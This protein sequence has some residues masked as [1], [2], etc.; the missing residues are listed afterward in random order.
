MTHFRSI[1]RYL[2]AS[3][4][5]AAALVSNAYA[6]FPG[7]AISAPSGSPSGAAASTASD[8]S[9]ATALSGTDNKDV[10]ITASFNGAITLPAAS[11]KNGQTVTITDTAGIGSGSANG[12]STNIV[13]LVVSNTGTETIVIDG[14]LTSVTR[15]MLWARG[16]TVTLRSNGSATWFVTARRYWHVDPRSY[17]PLVWYDARRGITLNSSTVSAW[18]D[19]SG[20]GRDLAQST[21]ANQPI[22]L[23]NPS[24]HNASGQNAV[25]FDSTA[26]TMQTAS[27][28]AFASNTTQFL[29]AFEMSW[30]A[31]Q[32]GMLWRTNYDASK[33]LSYFP[34]RSTSSGIGNASSDALYSG[35]GSNLATQVGPFL[36]HPSSYTRAAQRVVVQYAMG[37]G[38]PASIYRSRG[39]QQ[40]LST[41]AAG[42]VGSFTQTII[43]G[44]TWVGKVAQLIIF[45]G[46]LA[47]VNDGMMLEAALAEVYGDK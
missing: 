41:G 37:T 3:L 28:V 6:G 33:G 9:T 20:N 31:A 24:G 27:G 47:T 4:F 42:S 12:S 5:A 39:V 14:G 45:D 2:L 26:K 10:R 34:M 1:R 40:A 13:Y 17:S 21:G 22:Y 7:A 36:A 35:Q 19:V 15:L 30:N 38:A 11:G 29:A 23:S 18:A 32:D 25:F 16:G 43:L 44:S 8:V 46:A